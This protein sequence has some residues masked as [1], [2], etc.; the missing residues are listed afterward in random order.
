MAFYTGI[1]IRHVNSYHQNNSLLF[2]FILA[3]FIDAYTEIQRI[4]S[5]RRT[6]PSPS[7]ESA[8][9]DDTPIKEALI[10]LLGSPKEYMR[11]FSWNFSEGLL[12]KLRTYCALFIQNA[13]SDE[14]DLIAIQ[15]YADKVWQGCLQAIDSLQENPKDRALFLN[16]LDKAITA[17]QRLAKLIA[18][19]VHQFRDD[20]NAIFYV[21]RHHKILD[22]LYGHRFIVKLM[23]KIYTKG[24]KEAHFFLV[25]KYQQRGFDQ[26]VSAIETAIKEVEAAQG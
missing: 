25:K 23:G 5:L 9:Q 3:E 1:T 15:H 6:T 8:P 12:A 22:K 7:N 13:E 18:R 21:L 26:V 14:K 2:Q 4:D 16:P 20:E 24:L 10:K 11:I 19:L 17:M